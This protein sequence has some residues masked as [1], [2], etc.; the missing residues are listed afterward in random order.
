MKLKELKWMRT[1]KEAWAFEPLPFQRYRLHFLTA[2]LND[3][4][5]GHRGY[6]C[7][8]IDLYHKLNIE[9]GNWS[10]LKPIFKIENCVIVP[11]DLWALMLEEESDRVGPKIKML[12]AQRTTTLDK[13]LPEP[14]KKTKEYL[15]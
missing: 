14:P 13:P 9:A 2:Q 5:P 8:E 11:E 3:Q 4:P 7:L 15:N 1:E 12:Y 10:V 6:G